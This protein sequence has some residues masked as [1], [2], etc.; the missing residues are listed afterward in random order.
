MPCTDDLDNFC[1]KISFSILKAYPHLN[2]A[3]IVPL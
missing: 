2:S 1:A 3:I